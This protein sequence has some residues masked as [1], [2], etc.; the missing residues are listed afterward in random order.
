M[1]QIVQ[2]YNEVS[3]LPCPPL[4]PLVTDG[5]I[6][7]PHSTKHQLGYVSQSS[8]SLSDKSLLEECISAV[9]DYDKIK[10]ELEAVQQ[11]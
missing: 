1:K 5:E 2:K 6:T 9:R 3:S 10:S 4:P 8:V 11:R 7:V